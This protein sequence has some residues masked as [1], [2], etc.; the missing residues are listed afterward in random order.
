M[1][2]VWASCGVCQLVPW[3]SGDVNNLNTRLLILIWSLR[4]HQWSWKPQ[5]AAEWVYCMAI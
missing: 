4:G 3:C 5:I 2:Q 1:R